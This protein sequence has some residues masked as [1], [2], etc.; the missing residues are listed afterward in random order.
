MDIHKLNE[1]VKA[2]TTDKIVELMELGVPVADTRTEVSKLLEEFFV[3]QV[4][5][6]AL[7]AMQ[8]HTEINHY[9]EFTKLGF[10][11]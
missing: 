1:N 6:I 4:T 5:Q 11:D 9:N 7:K 2:I 3:A 8:Q 10:T